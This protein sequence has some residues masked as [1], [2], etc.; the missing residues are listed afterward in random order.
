MEPDL[1]DIEILFSYVCTPGVLYTHSPFLGVWDVCWPIVLRIHGIRL[2]VVFSHG[3]SP[4]KESIVAQLCIVL[5]C[6]G[7]ETV[8]E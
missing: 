4:I 1:P 7:R 5:F 6:I 2:T 3:I 8:R